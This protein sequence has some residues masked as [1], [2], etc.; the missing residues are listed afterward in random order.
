[1]L[2]QFDNKFKNTYKYSHCDLLLGLHSE[3]NN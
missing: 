1:M 2:E 3:D